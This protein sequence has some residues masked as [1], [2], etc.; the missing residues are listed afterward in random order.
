MV[1]GVNRDHIGIT[2]HISGIY[3]DYIGIT[4]HMF[5]L[6]WDNGKNSQRHSL[7]VAF[8]EP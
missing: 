7:H 1:Y 8:S 6:Y 2:G 4:G 5:G 3:R